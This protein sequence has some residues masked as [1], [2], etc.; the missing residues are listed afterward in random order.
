MLYFYVPIRTCYAQYGVGIS[1][2]TMAIALKE[3]THIAP[4]QAWGS[5]AGGLF[6]INLHGTVELTVPGWLDKEPLIDLHKP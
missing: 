2:Y 5:S 4:V 6:A 3:G 1:A